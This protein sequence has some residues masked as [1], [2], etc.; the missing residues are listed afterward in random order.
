[1]THIKCF[2]Q[3]VLEKLDFYRRHRTREQ[4]K[5]SMPESLE[6]HLYRPDWLWFNVLFFLNGKLQWNKSIGATL[7][8]T[9]S[10][11]LLFFYFQTNQLLKIVLHIHNF[12]WSSLKRLEKLISWQFCDKII[13]WETV[14]PQLPSVYI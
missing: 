1:M 2:D 11:V 12:E 6:C 7:F 10:L 4:R 3:S 14:S 13:F 9:N 5:Q 8:S